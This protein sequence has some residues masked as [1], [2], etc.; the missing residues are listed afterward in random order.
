MNSWRTVVVQTVSAI[1][2]AGFH[3][4]SWLDWAAMNNPVLTKTSV[5]S[6]AMLQ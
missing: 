5:N 4:R 1:A 3:R 6:S 2:D